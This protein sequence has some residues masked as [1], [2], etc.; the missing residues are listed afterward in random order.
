MC[1]DVMTDIRALKLHM[2]YARFFGPKHWPLTV[3]L[4]GKEGL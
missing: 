4:L 1:N 3:A 2:S